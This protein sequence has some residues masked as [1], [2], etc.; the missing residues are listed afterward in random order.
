MRFQDWSAVVFDLDGTVVEL[1]IDW[2]TLWVN[3]AEELS[4]EGISTSDLLS[5][6]LL[7]SATKAD[8]RS[9]AESMISPV[10]VKGAHKSIRLPLADAVESVSGP[11]AICS[12]NCEDACRVALQRHGLL[13]HVDVI[14]GRDTLNVWKPNPKP[15]EYA[16]EQLGIS[17]G[18]ALFVGDSQRD[19]ITARR[20][21]VEFIYV[22][23]ATSKSS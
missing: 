23:D 16:I 21:N 5:W 13:K 12:L 4:Q 22:S 11:V 18:G 15:L 2:E 19:A 10:E 8:K 3:L 20:A 14:I 9:T 7:E 1:P 6:E 17:R